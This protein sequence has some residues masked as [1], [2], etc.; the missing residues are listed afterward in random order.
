[1][2][3]ELLKILLPKEISEKYDLLKIKE[4]EKEIIFYLT[5]K[6][7]NLPETAK[8]ARSEGEKIVKNGYRKPIELIDHTVKG[9]LSYLRITR[10]RWK[11]KGTNISFENNYKL[12]EKGMKCTIGFGN[13]L[14]SLG[15]YRRRKFFSSWENIRNIR[16]KDFSLVSRFKRLFCH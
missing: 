4:K 15:K 14:K 7:I 1:M 8:R 10:R 9:K 16:E 2:K 3:N 13:F 12:H 6:E 5:E 11:I